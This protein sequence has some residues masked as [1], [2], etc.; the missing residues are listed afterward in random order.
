MVTRSLASS[1]VF[2]GAFAAC[3]L[4]WGCAQ[5]AGLGDDYEP[6]PFGG[7]GG[8]G[9][10][11][12]AA[13]GGAG[14]GGEASGTGGGGG[15]GGVPT[16]GDTMP[17]IA[18]PGEPCA[19]L[20]RSACFGHVQKLVLAC[21]RAALDAPLLWT[22]LE[23]C[24]GNDLCDSR[25][26]GEI[27][28]NSGTC[29]PV[30]PLCVGA[31][32]DERRCDGQTHHICGPDLVSTIA[33]ECGTPALCQLTIDS[34]MNKC[35][36]C[37]AGEYSCDGDT[38]RRC[39]AD[40]LGYEAPE[41][42]AAQGL[43]CNASTGACDVNRCDAG[44][45]QCEGSELRRCDDPQV[46]FV[47]ERTCAAGEFC[48]ADGGEC[49]ACLPNQARC[50]A[51]EG[52]AAREVCAPDGQGFE[53]DDCDDDTPFCAG[54]APNSRC[55]ACTN[56]AHCAEQ[57]EPCNPSTCNPGTNE[58]TF[59]P[60]TG[61]FDPQT[62]GDCK[63]RVCANGVV[64]FEPNTLD[65]PADAD[66]S[67]C[68]VPVCKS[69]GTVASGP[70]TVGDSCGSGG[71]CNGEGVCGVCTPNATT[72]TADG[73]GTSTCSP[74]GQPGPGQAC[75]PAT[76]HCAGGQC[77]ACTL[78]DHCTPSGLC[79]SATC[80]PASHACEEVT[81]PGA[82]LPDTHPHNC[83]ADVC[84]PNGVPSERDDANDA[85]TDPDPNDCSTVTCNGGEVVSTPRDPGA[86][87]NDGGVQGTC[88]GAG[89]CVTPPPMTGGEGVGGRGGKGAGA[90]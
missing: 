81:T 86:E 83:K 37:K 14:S 9:A 44:D 54:D 48:D 65:A 58:C 53:R 56:D 35:A 11:G 28:P 3:L 77:F 43:F 69:D 25:S 47:T 50:V 49:D 66:K 70:A 24:R 1:R 18:R 55:V 62:P 31:M 12:G 90:H 71:V 59:D 74:T 26:R 60:Q 78:N 76:P 30:V 22:E 46:G 88:D 79:K 16:L 63:T 36:V 89:D 75:P 52:T 32:P 2:A 38:R 21:K 33:L 72:C 82:S 40:Q 64:T 8:G 15:Q 17:A 19:E 10:G 57:G 67:D 61:P 23:Y 42:C 80:N 20:G 34:A 6:F 84:D 87:C 73:G 85:P 51:G 13:G 45:H 41:D 68:G 7:G 39:A 5:V 4:G 27:G 29:Q